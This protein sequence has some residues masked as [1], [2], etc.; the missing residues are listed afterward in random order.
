MIGQPLHQA[1]LYKPLHRHQLLH[2]SLLL[3]RNVVP[4]SYTIFNFFTTNRFTTMNRL[5]SAVRERCH[6]PPRGGATSSVV[7][8]PRRLAAAVPRRSSSS[9]HHQP[10]RQVYHTSVVEDVPGTRYLPNCPQI[11]CLSTQLTLDYRSFL[12]SEWCKST[13]ARGSYKRLLL[14]SGFS[15]V[16]N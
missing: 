3:W 13:N 6:I 5:Q 11:I 14:V 9:R 1:L 15:D 12:L 10:S 8:C 4:F 16:M 7:V 2:R